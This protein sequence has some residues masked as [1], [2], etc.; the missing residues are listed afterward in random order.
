MPCSTVQTSGGQTYTAAH[1]GGGNNIDVE[2]SDYANCTIGIYISSTDGPASLD[3][4]IVNGQFGIGIYVDSVGTMHQDHTSICV[5][6]T[7]SDATCTTGSA[8]SPGTGLDFV[9]T[10]KLS[11]DHTNIDAYVAG[12]AT[13]PC[14]NSNNN[15]TDDHTVITNATY[16]WSYEGGKLNFNFSPGHDSPSGPP[17]NCTGSGVGIGAQ[18]GKITEY[19]TGLTASSE[20]F[21]I[22]AGPDGNLWFTET[23]TSYVGRITTAGSITEFSAGIT[24]NSGPLG[25]AAGPDGN[26]WFAQNGSNQIG[27]I[28]TAGTATEFAAGGYPYGIAAGPNGNVWFAE[29]AGSQIAEITPTGVITGFGVGGEPY[30]VALGPDGNMWFT[31]IDGNVGRITTAGAN[32]EFPVPG[33]PLGITTGPDGNVW[34]TELLGNIVGR[35][36]TAGAITAFALPNG[37][38]GPYSI[39]AGPDGNLWFAE[40][41]G[42]RIGRIT[43]T[44][45]ISEFAL[46]NGGSAP[47]SIVAGPD[48]NMWFTEGSGN[49]IGK[50]T[51]GVG[52]GV[53]RSH[54]IHKR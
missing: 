5:N 25:I 35:I 16:P 8:S 14:P 49:R 10:P 3:H 52:P 11:I 9:N 32:A 18:P 44:G 50:I 21:G 12:F 26:L 47:T 17:G 19:S 36:T 1:L 40:Q 27:Q 39:A 53:R 29:T 34:F 37:G 42:N 6:G 45:T 20:P 28:T 30:N 54:K 43:T 46:P 23:A 51:T 31:D 41:Q 15:I 48:G 33:F 24:A 22:A 38:S 4:T 7:N 2:S 13:I